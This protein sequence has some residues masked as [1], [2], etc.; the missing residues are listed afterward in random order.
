MNAVADTRTLVAADKVQG[1]KIYTATGDNLGSIEDIMI[2][3]KS[4]NIAYAIMSFGGF[5]GIGGKY[6]PL[7]WSWLRYDANLGGYV[8]NIDRAQLEM[9]PGCGRWY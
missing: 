1:A 5:L 3:E 6:H 7:P 8:V 4:G 9:A 2:E